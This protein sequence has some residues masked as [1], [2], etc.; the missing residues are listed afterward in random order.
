MKSS[1]LRGGFRFISYAVLAMVGA[2][3]EPLGISG[4]PPGQGG[5]AGQGG[6]AGAGGAGGK[7]GTGGASSSGASSSSSSSSGAS[8][9]SSSSS[10]ASSSSSGASSSS[11]GASSSSGGS[12]SSSSGSGASSSGGGGAGGSGVCTD[13]QTQ[14]C[15]SGPIGTAG[16]GACT[17]GTET[18]INGAWSTC[19]GEVIPSAETCDGIDND[20]NGVIDEGNPGGGAACITGQPGIC[21][22]GTAMC[23]S[24]TITCHANNSPSPETCDKIDNDCDGVIDNGNPGGGAACNTGQFGICAAGT[25]TCT[26][27]FVV[28]QAD[29]AGNAEVCDGIDNNC[30]G[31]ID[32]GNPGGGNACNTGQPGICAAGTSACSFGTMICNRNNLPAPETCDG[33]D[34]NC[35]GVIDDG[36]PGGGAACNTGQPGICTTGTMTC[37]AGTISC[38]SNNTATAELCDGIDN[39]CDGV[40]D[41]GN[42]GGGACNT[43]LPGACATGIAA[44]TAGTIVCSATTQP[45]P[46]TCD[47]IDNDCDGQ[48]DEGNPGGGVVCTLGLPGCALGTSACSGGAIICNPP[49]QQGAEVCDGIDNDCDGVIDDGNPGGGANCNTG[50]PGNCAAGTSA[51]TGGVIVCNANNA[52]TPETCD[53]I[54]ND[55]DGQVDEGNPGGGATCAT[56]LPGACGTGTS[57]C[58]AGTIVCN[59]NNAPSTEICDNIDNDCDGVVDD[60]NIGGGAACNTGMAGVCAAGT[61]KCSGGT[62]QCI[63]VRTAMTEVCDGLDNDCNGQVDN[64]ISGVGSSCN[65]GQLGACGIGTTA[66]TGGTIVCNATNSPSLET[67]DG[68]DNDCDGTID[69]GTPGGGAACNT[70][71]SGICAAGTMQCKDGA[72]KCVAT[73]GI[74]ELCDN[75]DNDCDGVVDNGNPGGGAPCGATIGGCGEYTL[76]VNGSYVCRGTFVAPPSVGAPGNPGTQAQPVSTITAGLEMAKALNNGA[77]VCVCA[78]APGTPTIYPEYVTM[79]EGNSLFGG[80][81]CANWSRDIA[82]Y[83]TRI[84]PPTPAWPGVTPDPAMR[85]PAGITAATSVDG[86]SVYSANVLIEPQYM[87]ATTAISVENASPVLQDVIGIGG[88]GEYSYGLRVSADVKNTHHIT[89]TRG[90]YKANSSGWDRWQSQVVV[91]LTRTTGTFTDVVI[92]AGG[93]PDYSTGFSC[94]DCGATTISGGSIDGGSAQASPIGMSL[95]GDVAGFAATNTTIFSGTGGLYDKVYG[96]KFDNCV[97]APILTNVTI[98]AADT[99]IQGSLGVFSRGAQCAPTILGSSIDAGGDVLDT[100]IGVA[101]TDG[102]ACN[103]MDSVI[104]NATTAVQCFAGGCGTFSGN[105]LSSIAAA[106]GETRHIEVANAN[107]TFDSNEMF[108][109]ACPSIWSSS[110]VEWWNSATFNNS[111]AALTNNVFHDRPCPLIGVDFVRLHEGAAITMHNNTIQMETCTNCAAKRALVLVLPSGGAKVR[112]NIFVNAGT[113]DFAKG[114]GV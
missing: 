40:I 56:G 90:R 26:G 82:N 23:L 18:C 6:E 65:T 4:P 49:V 12:S 58:V 114:F 9:S 38:K 104:T 95:S 70:G 55:C 11:S 102:S 83:E 33:I 43:G 76:C 47:G 105:T 13:G 46:E 34:N 1:E 113:A 19:I 17:S 2:A 62:V 112:N 20:C 94:N 53:G 29:I 71:L 7:G 32:E 109:P 14:A 63:A 77:D 74:P 69:D 41:N 80:Y 27:G 111:T 103:L 45:T 3:C 36:N 99:V 22:P 97:G 92:Y 28:C 39:D 85:I 89:V 24:G 64:G 96:V 98:T 21:G 100:S 15:Y 57:T 16:I 86:M 10:G 61:M 88:N 44:C 54:D 31:W 79:S 37:S 78:T 91:G 101:C 48:V 93:G 42:P 110:R 84:H 60:R 73:G 68:I 66:C 5:A 108:L 107:P 81:N 51:C 75:I 67:C 59:G 35:D 25:L 52:G 87:R 72:I 50:L 106:I 8:S 30:D